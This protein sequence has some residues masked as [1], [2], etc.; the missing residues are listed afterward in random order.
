MI[1]YEDALQVMSTSLTRHEAIDWLLYH[2]SRPASD[3]KDARRQG[4]SCVRVEIKEPA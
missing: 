1:K 4:Y 3:W 2:P